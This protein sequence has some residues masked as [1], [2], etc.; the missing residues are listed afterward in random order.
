MEN[1]CFDRGITGHDNAVGRGHVLTKQ[2][3]K[4]TNLDIAS[5]NLNDG[6]ELPILLDVNRSVAWDAVDAVVGVQVFVQCE[7]EDR[8]TALSV[9]R[10]RCKNYEAG[11][12]G[13]D[14]NLEVMTL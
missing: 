3:I 13:I 8:G 10:K 6:T 9:G 7:L 12:N 11:L 14:T 5:S 2:R 1:E 4:H